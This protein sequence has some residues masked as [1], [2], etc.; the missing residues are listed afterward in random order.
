P[1][2]DTTHFSPRTLS[3][4]HSANAG[5][6]FHIRLGDEDP[7]TLRFRPAK[8]TAPNFQVALGP[9]HSLPASVRAYHGTLTTAT[10]DRLPAHMAVVN[11]A[12][13]LYLAV[14]DTHFRVSTDPASGAL[15]ATELLDPATDD[16]HCDLN[17]TGVAS[18]TSSAALP[19]T[20]GDPI[21]VE[22]IA[23]TD[24]NIAATALANAEGEVE[25][26]RVD[27]PQFRLG[28]QYDASLV[29][30]LMIFVLDKY[31]TGSNASS[32]PSTAAD[33]LALAATVNDVYERQLGLRPLLQEIILSPDQPSVTDPGQTLSA[34]SSWLNSNRPRSSY[35]WGHAARFGL[36][37]G[38]PSG[39]I[40]RAYVGAYGGSSGISE[41]EPQFNFSLLAH[42]LGHNVGSNHTNGGVMNP[43]LQSN[44]EDFYRTVQ[45]NTSLTGAIQVYNDMR[46]AARTYGEA[47]LR[48]AAE[49]P[50]G[51]DDTINAGPGP[52][53][54]NPLNN[55]ADSVLLGA[56]NSVLSLVEV[57][58]VFPKEAGTAQVVGQQIQFTP[59]AGYSGQAWFTYTLQGNVGNNGQG[60]KHAADVFVNVNGSSNPPATNPPLDT[61]EDFIE[62]EFFEPIRL[63]VLLNDEGSGRLWIG[64]VDVLVDPNGPDQ[65]Y[66]GTSLS[67]V[68]AQ[69]LQGNGSLSIETRFTNRD[70]SPS[71]DN[72]GYLVYTPGSPELPEV[73]IQYTVRDS[74]GVTQNQLARLVAPSRLLASVSGTLLREPLG[75]QITV[76]FDRASADDITNP[77]TVSFNLAGSANAGPAGADYVVS[78]ATSFDPATGNGTVVIPANTT[79]ADFI[80]AVVQ[81]S[82]P[83]A[84]E[85]IQLDVLGSST[86]PL[87]QF[88]NFTIGI[89][90]T[91]DPI[92]TENFDNFPTGSNAS[93]LNGWENGTQDNFNWRADANGTPSSSTGPSQD[94]TSG[95]GRYMYVESSSPN[96]PSR[97]ADLI[98]PVLN[99][100]GESGVTLTFFYNMYG[101][102]MGDLHIDVFNGSA[103]TNDVLLLSGQQHNNGNTW[104]EANVSLSGFLQNGVRVRFRGITG[105]NFR[106]DMAIDDVS[107]ESTGS[108]GN[109]PPV[110]LAS[111]SGGSPNLGDAVYLAVAATGS[112]APSYQWR[113]NGINLPGANS[114]AYQITSFA[115]GDAGSYDC[116]VSN[117]AGSA[118]SNT[119]ILTNPSGLDYTTWISGFPEVSAASTSPLDD[120]DNDGLSELQEFAYGFRPDTADAEAQPLVSQ[121]LDPVD[122]KTYLHLTYRRRIGGA[123][124]TGVNYT[125]D[126]ITYTIQLNTALVPGTWNNLTPA[127][128]QPVGSP[129]DNGDGTE[130]VT[131][132]ILPAI[133]DFSNG[134]CF[135]RLAISESS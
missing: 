120:F 62:T 80:I 130:T 33:F 43:S 110:I 101:S 21:P 48:N 122:G 23:G 50:F 102:N 103:W 96:Y 19:A 57:G 74:N 51:A 115:S 42:E 118:T 84:L 124:V 22:L 6:P 73:I 1:A 60:W 59:Q 95:N 56:T 55:D 104:T 14:D 127:S 24:P 126:G 97:R 54:F 4:V 71:Q 78:G 49:I 100:D 40:G 68:G 47:P 123:G 34:F 81:D 129:V 45:S 53:T 66:A 125:A 112:P 58:S 86:L 7:M 105:N 93:P 39:V 128:A 35:S 108:N 10:G 32:Y 117:S 87:S 98:S 65:N 114:P 31:T 77:E 83:E 17:H 29:D 132:R 89:D 38:S 91:L 46:T 134:E 119:A 133:E 44:Q 16:S 18:L 41:N 99:L 20:T 88:T 30:M 107:V 121:F 79:D 75:D 109:T 131:V 52:A 15:L 94:H 70:G 36:V 76:T 25:E 90:D 85:D 27:H 64:E 67:L 61:T 63:N 82:T 37:D 111:P 9:D 106:G 8:V 28:P 92:L 135:A 72:N 113:R 26:A 11:D 2:T 12:V 5:H 3:L 69:L 13:S 116:V